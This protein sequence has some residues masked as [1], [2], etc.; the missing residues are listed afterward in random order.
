MQ[1]RGGVLGTLWMDKLVYTD[2]NVLGQRPLHYRQKKKTKNKPLKQKTK[3]K[4]YPNPKHSN[5]HMS[6]EYL[7]LLWASGKILQINSVNFLNEH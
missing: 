1:E 7:V 2:I 4:N 5:K 6:R 3:Q